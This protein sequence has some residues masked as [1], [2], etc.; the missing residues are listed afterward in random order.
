LVQRITFLEY[1]L[2]VTRKQLRTAT[3][4][5]ERPCYSPH[6]LTSSVPYT[7]VAVTPPKVSRTT[8]P[9]K[10]PDYTYHFNVPIVGQTGWFLLFPGSG[11]NRKV[12]S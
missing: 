12:F 7:T 4:A 2:T 8:A 9:S 1:E 10:L 3:L 11:L 5:N 6:V